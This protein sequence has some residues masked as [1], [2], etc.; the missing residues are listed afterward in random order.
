M[1]VTTPED[2]DEHEALI[3][4]RETTSDYICGVQIPSFAEENGGLLS[5]YACMVEALE[6]WE[7]EFNT[8]EEENDNTT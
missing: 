8:V 3:A 6:Y 2:L 1:K 4:I 5:L 7:K